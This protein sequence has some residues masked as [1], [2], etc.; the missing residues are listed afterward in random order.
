MYMRYLFRTE[1]FVKK[2]NVSLSKAFT[3]VQ[4]DATKHYVAVD[5]VL[6]RLSVQ[7]PGIPTKSRNK[8]EKHR[9]RPERQPG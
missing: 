9:P 5:K 2:K 8:F 7:S 4:L 3:N 1:D 6:T